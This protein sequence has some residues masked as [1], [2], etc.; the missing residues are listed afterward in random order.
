MF[1]GA[2]IIYTRRS[3]RDNCLSIYFQ[4]LGEQLRYATD[5]ADSAHYYRQHDQLM[6]HWQHLLGDNI[7][8]MDYDRFVRE[9]EPVLGDLLEF[10][11]LPWDDRCLQFQEAGSLV[12]TASVWQVRESLHDRSS[13]RWRHYERYIDTDI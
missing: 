10:L 1:P 7:F 11:G 3:M 8:T 12:K 4:Q 2:R 9:P 13:G 5:L 6:A